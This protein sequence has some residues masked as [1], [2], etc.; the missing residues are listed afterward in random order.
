[1]KLEN[2]L[3]NADKIKQNKRRETLIQNKDKAIVSKKLV[4][5][6]KDVPVKNKISEFELKE[7]DKNNIFIVSAENNDLLFNLNNYSEPIKINLYN[8]RN[9]MSIELYYL[10]KPKNCL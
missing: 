2:V 5:L 1:M 7:I 8:N 10:Y 9:N 6:K 3:K 4:T